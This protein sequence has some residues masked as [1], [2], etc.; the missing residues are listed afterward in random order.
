MGSLLVVTGPPGSGKSTVT[1][2][3]AERA[4]SSVR[5]EGDAFFGFLAKGAVEPWL[6]EANPQNAIVTEAAACA[7]GR[8]AAGGYT[9]VYD[10]VVGPWFL[11]TFWTATGLPRIDYVVLL[12]SLETCVDRVGRRREHGFRDEAATR[13]MHDEFVRAPVDARHVLVDEG[14]ADTVASMVVAA[15]SSGKLTYP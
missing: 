10:G 12:P 3:L 15:A 14:A 1:R 9:T 2:I 8:F 6:A 5:I 13:K 11:R 4:T 7:A